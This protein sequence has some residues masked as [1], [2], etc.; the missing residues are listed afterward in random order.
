MT[1]HERKV[2]PLRTHTKRILAKSPEG[3]LFRIH[4]KQAVIHR[5]YNCPLTHVIIYAPCFS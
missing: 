4:P 3:F 1:S 5:R 2:F